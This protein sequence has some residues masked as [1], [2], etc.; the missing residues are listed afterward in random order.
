MGGGRGLSGCSAF[1]RST[2][3]PEP[4]QPPVVPLGKLSTASSTS[5]LTSVRYR[6]GSE[7]PRGQWAWGSHGHPAALGSFHLQRGFGYI[8]ICVCVCIC[9]YICIYINIYIWFWGV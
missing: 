5:S 1:R 7:R 2:R 8:Y 6:H 4:I 3:V 9:V